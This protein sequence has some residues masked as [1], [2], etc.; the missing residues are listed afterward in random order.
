MQNDEWREPRTEWHT[1]WQA[2][3]SP[4]MRHCDRL[5]NGHVADVITDGG[6]VIQLQGC[7]I[8]EEEIL[9]R[10]ECYGR[11]MVW[12]FNCREA[13]KDFDYD[14]ETQLSTWWRY[15]PRV[16][17]PKARVL[18]DVADDV[19]I[20]NM[21]YFKKDGAFIEFRAH[22]IPKQNILAAC[23]GQ[24]LPKSLY[25]SFRTRIGD[26]VLDEPNQSLRVR[27]RK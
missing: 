18:L 19:G 9:E 17:F 24:P 22:E 11:D 12:I 20:L 27:V 15:W 6:V 26:S 4:N 1:K 16:I 23:Q 2:D 8:S 5:R 25:W 10:E 7:Y 3:F 13:W 14:P 21:W